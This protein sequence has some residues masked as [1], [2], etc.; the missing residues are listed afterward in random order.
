M[1]SHHLINHINA[2]KY[3]KKLVFFSSGT[4]AL[5]DFKEICS[6]STVILEEK[7]VQPRVFC[8]L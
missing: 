4:D 2:R 8:I 5:C 1:K 3:K 6:N 7:P